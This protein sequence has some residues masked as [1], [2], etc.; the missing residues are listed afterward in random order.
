MGRGHPGF[1]RHSGQ[2][3]VR[4]GFVLQAQRKEHSVF[5]G[6]ATIHCCTKG[7]WTAR[8]PHLPWES[9]PPWEQPGLLGEDPGALGRPCLCYHAGPPSH[10]A[11]ER[12]GPTWKYGGSS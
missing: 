11:W 8:V 2:S 4:P 1:Q 7:T 9:G 3:R 5:T 10:L 12:W 6:V